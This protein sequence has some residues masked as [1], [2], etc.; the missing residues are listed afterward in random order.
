[1]TMNPRRA[2]AD[3]MRADAPLMALLAGGVFDNAQIVP[4]MAEPH[5]FDEVGRVRPSALVRLETTA[6]DGPGAIFDRAFV[7]V[8]FYDQAGYEVIDQALDRARALLHRRYIGDGA[9]EARHVDDVS[10]QYDDAILAYMHRSRYQV[11]R[12]RG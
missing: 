2:V 3:I 8:F 10:D 11:V 9:Y 5:P 1:M 7:V 4:G 6:N 12:Y